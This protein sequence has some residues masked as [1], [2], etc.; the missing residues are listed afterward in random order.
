MGIE[1]ASDRMCISTSHGKSPLNVGRNLDATCFLRYEFKESWRVWP[2]DSMGLMV[3][4]WIEQNALR[5]CR[6][7]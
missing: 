6:F 7:R 2:T 1:P 4:V 3:A 5:I